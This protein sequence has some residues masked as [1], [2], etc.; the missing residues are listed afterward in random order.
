MFIQLL[1]VVRL[2]SHP[3]AQEDAFMSG[4]IHLLQVPSFQ[5]LRFCPW[6]G[7][8]I[9]CNSL[10]RRVLIV[11]CVCEF[12]FSLDSC[13]G[14]MC[15][16]IDE[17]AVGACSELVFA[18]I[19]EMFPD[20]AVLLPSGFRIIPL[21]SKTVEFNCASFYLISCIFCVSPVQNY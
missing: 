16:G 4:D 13:V 15:T 7:R 11:C 3:L 10:L 8:P 17:N 21:H 2:E 14:Q 9:N 5:S 1:E 6:I 19:D 20:D 18:P 12:N